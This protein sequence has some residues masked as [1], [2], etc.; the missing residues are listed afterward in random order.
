MRDAVRAW[1]G[2]HP[3]VTLAIVLVILRGAIVLTG[4]ETLAFDEEL[5]RGTIAKELMD[6]LKLPLVAYRPDPYSLGSIVVS[7]LAVPPFALLGPTLVALKIVAVAFTLATLV[8][9]FALL[10]RVFGRRAAVAGGVLFVLAPPGPTQLS[11]FAMGF[12]TESVLFSLAIL[13]AWYRGLEQP[14]RRGRVAVVGLAMGAG[15]AFTYITTLTAAA[16][17]ASAAIARPRPSARGAGWFLLGLAVGLAP[18]A[19]LQAASGFEGPR[20]IATLLQPLFTDI[21]RAPLA[22]AVRLAR[23]AGGVLLIGL[24]QSY[25]FPS[26]AGVPGLALCY[27]Y[28]A[29]VVLLIAG[30]LIRGGASSDLLPLILWGGLFVVAYAMTGYDV[31]RQEDVPGVVNF[32]FF[33]PLQMVVL[34]LAAG[35][36]ARGREG[37]A[38][39]LILA[40]LGLLGQAALLSLHIP[41]HLAQYRGYSYVQLGQAWAGRLYPRSAMFAEATSTLAKFPE[42][43]RTFVYRGLFDVTQDRWPD[44]LAALAR[45]D[46]VPPAYRGIALEAVVGAVARRH[47]IGPDGLDALARPLSPRERD[48]LYRGYLDGFGVTWRELLAARSE[49]E[50]QASGLRDRFHRKLGALAAEEC[51]E[52][53]AEP[54]ATVMRDVYGLDEAGRR[55]A[56]RGI[57][58]VAALDF[59]ASRLFEEARVAGGAV[60]EPHRADFFWGVGWALRESF[61]EDALRALDWIARLPAQG[62]PAAR[63][64]L[65]AY[66]AWSLGAVR[67]DRP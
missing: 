39:L 18:W 23:K 24:P 2:A 9:L 21:S 58:E 34:V 8:A 47:A 46:E 54:C 15:V 30:F 32:R 36:I 3:L 44:P 22:T 57:G 66:E 5:Y 40:A 42:P 63:E 4:I 28:C 50:R 38:A 52:R 51:Y 53:R 49:F 7:V 10:A 33:A 25:A 55:Q 56:F 64:G 48:H 20:W 41:A 12:H 27:V 45:L 6:G 31:P 62:R 16:C 19:A 35:A 60:P 17:L 11:S 61:E 13:L 29:L 14:A 26:L 1:L 65:R 37:P 67:S 59:R 43:S